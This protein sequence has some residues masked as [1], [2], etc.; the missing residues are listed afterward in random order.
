MYSVQ[1]TLGLVL[2]CSVLHCNAG[3]Q[4]DKMARRGGN[5][6]K[7]LNQHLPAFVNIHWLPS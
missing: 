6:V 5:I 2:I 7:L 4:I 1:L 3:M